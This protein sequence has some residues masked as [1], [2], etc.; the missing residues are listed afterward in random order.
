MINTTEIF[1]APQKLK[2]FIYNKLK[3]LNADYNEIKIEV[4]EKKLNGED[5]GGKYIEVSD[6]MDILTDGEIV[7]IITKL[8][9]FHQKTEKLNDV[10]RV[11]NIKVDE[12]EKLID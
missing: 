8:K 3:E 6:S 11:F 5:V 10:L 7:S 12:I 2:L 4:S 9:G 1:N